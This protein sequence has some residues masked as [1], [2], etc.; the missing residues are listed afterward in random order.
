MYITSV[1]KNIISWAAPVILLAVSVWVWVDLGQEKYL[2]V[3]FLDVG[4]GDAIFVESPGGVQIL[5]D[6]GSGRQ[7]LR[8]LNTV[9]PIWDRSI[10]IIIATHPDKD[11]IGGLS[12]VLDRY[13]VETVMTYPPL[14]DSSHVEMFAR[15]L[16]QESMAMIIPVRGQVLEVEENLTLSIL[17]PD[18][19]VYGVD[20]NTASV[21]GRLEYHDFSVLLMGDAPKVVERTITDHYGGE[22]RSDIL[23]VG[24]HGSD[25][26]S[27]AEFIAA[28]SPEY[29]VI[30]AGQDNSYGHPHR[31]VLKRLGERGVHTYCTCEEGSVVFTTDGEK[32]HIQ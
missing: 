12:F 20:S 27:A 21:I 13:N 28:V 4:Q 9:M 5:I 24:H 16:A 25:T 8:S 10:D 11:H 32:V 14:S 3:A 6:G 30:Q 26:S 22:L 7:I 2:T 29:A 17:F 1:K 19:L 23:K 18:R 31:E 15:S